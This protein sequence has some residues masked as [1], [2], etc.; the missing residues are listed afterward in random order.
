MNITID[1]DNFV[2]SVRA[3]AHAIGDKTRPNAQQCMLVRIVDEHWIDVVCVDGHRI[4]KWHERVIS[5]DT[6]PASVLV[7]NVKDLTRWAKSLPKGGEISIDFTTGVI[8]AI[9]ATF[10][11][12]ACEDAFPDYETIFAYAA[13]RDRGAVVERLRE[14]GDA[15]GDAPDVAE[16]VRTIREGARMLDEATTVA[17]NG[18]YLAAAAKAYGGESIVSLAG[19]LDPIVFRSAMH[20]VDLTCIVMPVRK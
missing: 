20:G 5:G 13:E 1:R 17:V 4:A 9:C 11:I 3:V 16:H 2:E 12:D 18:R 7:R 19:K 15:L 10:S 8:D 6:G 14:L